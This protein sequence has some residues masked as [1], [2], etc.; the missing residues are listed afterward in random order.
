V[1]VL[2]VRSAPGVLGDGADR[3]A[4]DEL[5]LCA[6]HLLGERNRRM[7]VGSGREV[8]AEAQEPATTRAGVAMI[9]SDYG[10]GAPQRANPP[11]GAREP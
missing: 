10:H 7:L 2:M 1:L 6:W 5:M 4:S 8:I 9:A 3:T 11:A